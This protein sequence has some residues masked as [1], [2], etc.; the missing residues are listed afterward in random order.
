MENC[1]R[2]GA[3]TKD[4]LL[5]LYLTASDFDVK[6]NTQPTSLSGCAASSKVKAGA[7]AKGKSKAKAKAKAKRTFSTVDDEVS[8]VPPKDLEDVTTRVELS[9]RRNS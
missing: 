6:V 3:T 4:A 8:L 9:S 2:G 1:D 7:K 5:K